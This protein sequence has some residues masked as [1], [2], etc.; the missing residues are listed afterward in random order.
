MKT[1]F[2][3][4]RSGS[5]SIPKKNIKLFCGKPLVYWTLKALQDAKNIDSIVV[6]IDSDEFKHT[7]ESFNFS[8]VRCYWRDDKNAQDSSS[9]ESVMIEFIKKSQFNGDDLFVL[10]QA[11]SPLTRAID[12]D[13][14]IEQLYNENADSLLSAVISKQF[15]WTKQCKPINYDFENRPRR[16]DHQ[17][18]Y[19]ENGAF[20]INRIANIIKNKNRLSGNIS[21]YEMPASSSIDIDEEADWLMAEMLMKRY[22]DG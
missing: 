22:G 3:P 7:V 9:T 6:A 17:G 18:V 21:I 16:Q 14:A 1:A 20:Y 4:I 11:T 8:K 12:I 19:V 2:I 15:F 5:K 13:R 10:V